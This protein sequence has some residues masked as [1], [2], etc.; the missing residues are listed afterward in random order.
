MRRGPPETSWDPPR[1]LSSAVIWKGW[2]LAAQDGYEVQTES[3]AFNELPKP[4][5][6]TPAC[7]GILGALR[8]GICWGDPGGGTPSAAQEGAVRTGR[9][10]LVVVSEAPRTAVA[11]Q[12]EPAT[13][14]EFL[15][16]AGTHRSSCSIAQRCRPAAQSQGTP[17]PRRVLCARP[18]RKGCRGND[19]KEDEPRNG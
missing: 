13:T 18:R 9:K 4:E 3:M 11:A 7:G 14:K 5:G 2:C 12:S 19:Q 15:L 1:C 10:E 8:M 6:A 16:P 17:R